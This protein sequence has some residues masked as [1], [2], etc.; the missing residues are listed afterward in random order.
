MEELLRWLDIIPGRN[1][2]LLG[3]EGAALAE[4]VRAAYK[5]AGVTVAEELA[6]FPDATF[7]VS[8]A[9]AALRAEELRR[10]TVPGGCSAMLLQGEPAALEA[11]FRGAGLHAIQARRIGQRA[12]V[13]GTR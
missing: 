7:D 9:T 3:P 10:V 11:G 13:R 4:L 8:I 2:L 5:P 1:W 6:G 12:A